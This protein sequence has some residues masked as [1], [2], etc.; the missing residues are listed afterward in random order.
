MRW[1]VLLLFI[2][3]SL[4]AA[5]SYDDEPM[6]LSA[7][8]ADYKDRKITLKGDVVVEHELG[9]MCA[10]DVEIHSVPSEKCLRL[11]SILLK[12]K[13][14]ILLK[15]SGQLTC[16]GADLDYQQMKGF[17]SGDVTY[18]EL[19]KSKKQETV[20][21]IVKSRLM[22]LDIARQETPIEVAGK[23]FVQQITAVGDVNVNY[24]HD[25]I[26]SADQGLYERRS[27]AA[28]N[29]RPAGTITLRMDSSERFC[30]IINRNGDLIKAGVIK[31]DILT[32]ELAFEKANGTI[33]GS[34]EGVK[35]DQRIDFS[36]DTLLWDNA[37][38]Q[39][40]LQDNV[41]INQ[42]GLGRLE[43][44]G[45]ARI[46][47]RSHAGKKQLS[48]LET[49][50][51]TVIVFQ[52]PGKELEHTLTSYGVVA[53]DHIQLL[54]TMD[55]PKG[56]RGKVRDEE[57][58]SF[59]DDQGEIFADKAALYYALDGGKIVLSKVRLEGNVRLKDRQDGSGDILHYVIADFV[60]FIPEDKEMIFTAKAKR[61]VLFY[62][63]MNNVQ[64]S[65]PALKIKRDDV[66]QKE[67]IKGIGD[68]RF[69]FIEQEYMQLRKR[70]KLDTTEAAQP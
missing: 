63:K 33:Q 19:C 57:Q 44:D 34:R 59:L 35:T 28:E 5:E 50:G 11:G 43:T 21:L 6:T 42:A 62:D 51:K 20:P 24:N 29:S 2:A 1:A 23:S 47:Q 69:S 41:Q 48:L 65:A 27:A 66:T 30:K 55:S 22:T 14:N 68:V 39:I 64:V 25:F 13:V 12:D 70:F 10:Q 15:D 53:V 3:I 61:R 52:E 17:F 56:P 60:D 32:K 36:A 67:S 26:A 38:D 49:A 8:Q 45:E 18:S 7:V 37:N 4:D 16:E 46:Y 40:T 31:I 58:V 9:K 54:T